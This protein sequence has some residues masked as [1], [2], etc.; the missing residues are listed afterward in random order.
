MIMTISRFDIETPQPVLNHPYRIL[1]MVHLSDLVKFVG[2]FFEGHSSAPIT[3]PTVAADMINDI[4][5]NACSSLS[6]I[7]S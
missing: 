2:E 1:P 3:I 6:I 5:N 7:A 4:Q